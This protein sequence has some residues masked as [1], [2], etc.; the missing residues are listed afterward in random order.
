[1]SP[2]LRARTFAGKFEGEQ[3]ERDCHQACPIRATNMSRELP[4][5]SAVQQN[6]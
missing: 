6:G 1:M 5:V 3:A 4:S 2:Q